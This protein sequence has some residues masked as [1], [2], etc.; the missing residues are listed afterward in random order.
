MN[1]CKHS[2]KRFAKYKKML[3]FPC[4]MLT[5]NQLFFKGIFAHFKISRSYD[6]TCSFKTTSNSCYSFGGLVTL[7]THYSSIS[8]LN[9]LGKN[10][11]LPTADASFNL[12]NL[13]L[14]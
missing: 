2:L 4:V 12:P 3:L 6:S 9:E 1:I 14:H 10:C 13:S 8:C 5:Q 11:F 7:V